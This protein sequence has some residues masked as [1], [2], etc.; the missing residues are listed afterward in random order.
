MDS[1]RSFHEGVSPRRLGFCRARTCREYRGKLPRRLSVQDGRARN[2]PG[3]LSAVASSQVRRSDD[4]S[5]I[6]VSQQSADSKPVACLFARSGVHAH[7]NGRVIFPDPITVDSATSLSAKL[8]INAD[9]RWHDTL[10]AGGC[11][12]GCA[13]YLQVNMPTILPELGHNPILMIVTLCCSGLCAAGGT[14]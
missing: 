1:G 4:A 7:V 11:D 14:G 2:W 8:F 9:V 6:L 3:I 10:V 5:T 13:A 12:E